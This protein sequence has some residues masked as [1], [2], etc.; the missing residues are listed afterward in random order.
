MKHIT[1]NAWF[2]LPNCATLWC[3]VIGNYYQS[4]SNDQTTI[5]E[6]RRLPVWAD[7]FKM[8]YVASKDQW[9]FVE[10]PIEEYDH[11]NEQRSMYA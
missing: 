7:G 4:P 8:G 10:L 1:I 5:R 6:W 2:E 9:C 3:K 11:V